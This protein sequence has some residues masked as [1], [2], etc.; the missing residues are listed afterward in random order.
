MKPTLSMTPMLDR[1]SHLRGQPDKIANIMHSGQ[2]RFLIVIDGRPVISSNIERTE[3]SLKWQ[4]WETV[5]S[6]IA[7]GANWAFLGREAKSGETFFAVFLTGLHVP[8]SGA[9]ELATDT[10]FSPAVDLRSLATQ[11]VI[12]PEEQ[13][14]AGQATALAN[15]HI[16]SRCCGRCGAKT[17]SDNA[18]WRRTCWSCGR[19]AFPRMDPAVI[20]LVTDGARAVLA[21]EARFPE[22]M[23][24]TLAG[25]VE[26]GDDV[27]HAVRRET[28]EEVGLTVGRVEFLGAQPWPFPHTLMLGCL[29]HAES[30]D[31]SPDPTEI[32]DARWFSRADL[33]QM[34]NKTHPDGL[35]FPGAQ[36]IAYALIMHFLNNV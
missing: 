7:N 4:R 23:Y 24:S 34:N 28:F 20:M 25:F 36:S 27:A 2:S 33:K 35:W 5:A 19:T 8:P 9:P 12:T 30:A 31:L 22:N 16:N 29:A 18:G 11:G 26:P 1:M 21:H 10:P 15:W 17:R 6:F 3:A 32:E 14:L 13:S